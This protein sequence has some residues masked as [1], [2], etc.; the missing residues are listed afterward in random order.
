[1]TVH[2]FHGR[3]LHVDLDSGRHRWRE[4]GAERLRAFVG[5]IG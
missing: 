1:M 2:G 3:L 5:G 4:I